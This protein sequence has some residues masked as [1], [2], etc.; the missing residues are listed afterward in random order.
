MSDW[1]SFGLA[2]GIIVGVILTVIIVKAFNKDGRFK[3][4]YD[5]MQLKIR[6]KAYQYAF[7]TIVIYEALMCVLTSSET[8]VLPVTNFI[9]HFTAVIAGVLVQVTYCIWK[10]AYIGLNT[11]A[12]RFSVFCILIALLNLA[13]GIIAVTHGEMFVDGKLQDPFINLL[14]TGLFIVIGVELLIKHFTDSAA[15]EKE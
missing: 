11:H 7:W 15:A 6:G 12:G 13:I 5:E 14:I 8:L 3:T 1:K 9:L 4:R 2:L 10:G